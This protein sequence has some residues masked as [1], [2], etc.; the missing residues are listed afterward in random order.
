MKWLIIGSVPA[1]FAGVFVIR[2]F[3]AGEALQSRVQLLLGMALVVACV[4]IVAKGY[5]GARRQ[6][7]LD[8]SSEEVPVTSRA[9]LTILVGAAVGLIVGMTSVGS[10]SLMVVRL[11]L[12]YPTLNSRRLLG[13][14][15]VQAVPL[16]GATA[17]GHVL[18]GD[19]TLGLTSRS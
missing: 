12:V 7:A 9:A 2:L 8:R 16:V 6:R 15:L 17:L 14:D 19:F 4:G 3:G 10:G 18:V 13:T 5:L 11:M 1:A